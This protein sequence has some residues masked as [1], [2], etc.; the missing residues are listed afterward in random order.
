MARWIT[1]RVLVAVKTYPVP[2]QKTIEASCTGGVTKEGNW[3]R[4]FPVPYRSLDQDKRFERWQWIDV[5]VTKPTSDPRPESFKL[6]PDRIE[7]V[8]EVG[9][10]DGWRERREILRPLIRPSMCHIKRERD[11]KK[12]PTLGLFKPAQIRRLILEPTNSQWTADELRILQSDTLFQKAPNETLEKIPFDFKYEFRCSDP[13]CGSHT[14]TC[15]DWEMAQAYRRWRKRYGN[16]WEKAFRQR[17]EVDMIQKFDTH[18]F[19]GT[20]SQH[21]HI[22][23]VVGLFYPPK[24]TI[25]D[26]FDRPS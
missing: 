6:K 22:W 23:I 13:A 21:P 3:I 25:D 18:F 2:A 10:T 16:D 5:E 19:V 12:Y 26:L 15:T 9:K 11:E 14:M 20:H 4:L 8:G 7:I 17:F 24:L 1:K